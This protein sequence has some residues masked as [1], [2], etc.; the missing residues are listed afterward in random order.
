[1][2]WIEIDSE[3]NTFRIFLIA[4]TFWESILIKGLG[5]CKIFI[6]NGHKFTDLGFMSKHWK[7]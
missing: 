4:W 1:M 2:T 3:K 6:K 5:T 7:N